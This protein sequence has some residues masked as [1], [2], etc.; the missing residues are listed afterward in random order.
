M[1]VENRKEIRHIKGVVYFGL[2]A[3]QF[4][5]SALALIVGIIVGVNSYFAGVNDRLLG[6]IVMIAAAPF[7]FFGFFTWHGMLP[8]QLLPVFLRS[9][10]LKRTRLYYRPANK[11]KYITKQALKYKRRDKNAEKRENDEEKAS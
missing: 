3:R 11:Y 10:R 2:S 7:V 8:E 5:F 9:W 6:L 1:N 4:I